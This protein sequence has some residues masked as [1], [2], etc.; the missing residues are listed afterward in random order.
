MKIIDG[1]RYTINGIPRQYPI[2]QIRSGA[3]TGADRGALVAAKEL[4]I[5][6]AGWVP[7]GGIAEDFRTPPGV[8]GTFPELVETPNRDYYE[9]T[10]W[11]VR[12]S[13]ATLIVFIGSR[14]I[15]PGT[16]YTIDAAKLLG[17]SVYISDGSADEESIK[18]ILDWL[19][20]IGTAITLNVA[21]PTESK[22][23]GSYSAAYNVV[24]ALLTTQFK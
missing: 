7:R 18:K 12:D 6:I 17:R 24:K 23:P 20:T 19:K 11:N 3:Q 21:G 2:A 5:P 15:T 22:L 4:G 16:K 13:H 1:N 10:V 14:K 9:R 8:L